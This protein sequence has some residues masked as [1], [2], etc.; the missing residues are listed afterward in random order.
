MARITQS[1]EIINTGIMANGITTHADTLSARKID[2]PF[3][4]VLL[5]EIE[6]CFVLNNE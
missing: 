5:K 4:T 6:T 3:A 2:V 1:Q